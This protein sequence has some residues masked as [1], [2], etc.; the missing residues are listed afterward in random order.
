MNLTSEQLCTAT[1]GSGGAPA[2]IDLKECFGRRYRVRYEDSYYAEY[3]QGARTRDPWLMIIPCQLGHISPHGGD[4]LLACTNRQRPIT[5]KRLLA[6]PGARAVQDGEDGITVAF[7]ASLFDQVAKIMKARRRRQLTPE[8]RER[9]AK[10]GREA[11]QRN[12]QANVENN[13]RGV[14]GPSERQSD[15]RHPDETQ[16][17]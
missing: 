10:I 9:L 7:P 15:G 6:L 4:E 12:R 1:A 13:G 5:A 17:G 11:L 8:Q 3:G 16:H 2:C 14:T